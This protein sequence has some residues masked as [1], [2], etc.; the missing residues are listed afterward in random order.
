MFLWYVA[1]IYFVNAIL[2]TR[3]V[4]R[5]LTR[6]S[7]SI[8]S[9]QWTIALILGFVW[10]VTMTGILICLLGRFVIRPLVIPESVRRAERKEKQFWQQKEQRKA[11]K[12]AQQQARDLNLPYP[13]GE[14]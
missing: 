13:K 6:G 12:A 9:D 1:N 7:K 10:P 14:E 11:Q 3:I 4:L 5:R 8:T 2:M